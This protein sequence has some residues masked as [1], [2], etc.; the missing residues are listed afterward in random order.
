MEILKNFKL[1]FKSSKNYLVDSVFNKVSIILK[2]HN[3]TL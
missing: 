1:E 2:Y 3:L